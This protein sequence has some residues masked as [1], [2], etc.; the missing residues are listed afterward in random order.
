MYFD[1]CTTWHVSIRTQLG[2]TGVHHSACSAVENV[3]RLVSIG[4]YFT[5]YK[6]SCNTWQ[7]VHVAFYT[8]YVLTRV[9]IATWYRLKTFLWHLSIVSRV[10]LYRSLLRNVSNFSCAW[11]YHFGLTRVHIHRFRQVQF[12][13][14]FASFYGCA[15]FEKG[16]YVHR[17][18]FGLVFPGCNVQYYTGITVHCTRAQVRNI[19]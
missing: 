18:R 5:V 14:L 12:L 9:H 1:T 3:L 17:C 4:T 13:L 10:T 19:Q 7:Y 11:L 8:T 16:F 15:L 6:I 2:V